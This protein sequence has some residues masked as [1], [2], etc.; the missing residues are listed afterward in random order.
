[1]ICFVRGTK[2]VF[3]VLESLIDIFVKYFRRDAGVVELARLESVC[4]GNRT[5]GSNPTLSA[6]MFY[7]YILKSLKDNSH[8]Y[9]S[10]SDCQSRLK[11]HNSGKVRSTK[12]HRP[13]KLHYF[14][15]FNTRAEAIK[16]ER[17]FKT[18]DGYRWLKKKKII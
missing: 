17:F 13:W 4:T 2:V 12:G 9:G 1:M 14:E 10:S 5:V 18:I 6:Q 3:F 16:R 7:T 15:E 8:Y 11:I